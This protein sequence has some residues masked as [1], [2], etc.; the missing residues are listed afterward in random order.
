MIRYYNFIREPVERVRVCGTLIEIGVHL[1]HSILVYYLHLHYKLS[2]SL[3]Y[4]CN[5]VSFT[6]LYASL[7]GTDVLL[8]YAAMAY[9]SG[10]IQGHNIAAYWIR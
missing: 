4:F 8:P 3:P 6:H 2:I 10:Q 1:P 9:S 7:L 5:I